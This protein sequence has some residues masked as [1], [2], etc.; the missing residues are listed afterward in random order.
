MATKGTAM[1]MIDT[2][3]SR[4]L[5]DS[6]LRVVDSVDSMIHVVKLRLC[7]AQVLHDPALRQKVDEFDRTADDGGRGPF[8]TEADFERYLSELDD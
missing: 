6:A 3:G 5:V 7:A 2:A 4:R 1:A 8:W